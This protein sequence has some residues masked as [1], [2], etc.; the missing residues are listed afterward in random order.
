MLKQ[1]TVEAV[2]VLLVAVI[3]LLVAVSKVHS[4]RVVA[5]A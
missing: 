5:E 1:C 3:V 2:R 4:V